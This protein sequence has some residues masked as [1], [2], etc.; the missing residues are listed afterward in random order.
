[1]AKAKQ[2]E[3]K[4]PKI[5]KS[6]ATPRG[7]RDILPEEFLYYDYILKTARKLFEYYG[8]YRI[9]TP[10]LEKAELFIRTSG[11]ESEV[12]HK[13]MYTLRTKD[14]GEVLALRPEGTAPVIRAY[15]ENALFNKPQPVKLY[16]FGPYFRH[17]K[18]QFGRYREFYQLGIEAIGDPDPALDTQV[19]FLTYLLLGQLGL[20]KKRIFFKLNSIGCKECRRSYIRELK[21]YYKKN[22]S[23]ICSDCRRRLKTN[24]LRVLDCKKE[25]CQEIKEGAPN[26][27]DY[28]CEE[29]KSH[30]KRLL[31]NLDA[32]NI[33]YILDKTVVRGLDYYTRTVFEVFLEGEKENLALGGGGR[34]DLLSKSLK[35]PDKPG[36]GVALGVERLIETLKK[37]K[38]K[39]QLPQPD[40]FLVQMGDEAK[41]V[42]FQLLEKLRQEGIKI[43]E[44]IG[45]NSLRAQLKNADR[46]NTPFVLILGQEEVLNGMIIL[47][48]MRSGLQ[49]TFAIDKIIKVLKERLKK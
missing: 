29:C 24:P 11:K 18:P 38:I 32:L 40:V 48:D 30:F 7:M 35:G 33:P 17:E 28:L 47:K 5:K 41:R 9:E 1:M 12:V 42:G 13:E 49:E 2:K 16:Y 15:I 19:I 4:T 43:A 22:Y 46:L 3:V 31:E 26:I 6:L 8:Y 45:K 44:N 27:L 39:L 14:K 20:D 10:I 23:K 25:Q 36:V 37:N 21:K 34:Y